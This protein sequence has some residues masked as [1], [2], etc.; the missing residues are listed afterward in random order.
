MEKAWRNN[1]FVMRSHLFHI[2]ILVTLFIIT[3]ASFSLSQTDQYQ[4][5]KGVKFKDGSVIMGTVT[6]L[7]VD[8]VTIRVDNGETIV[9]KFGDVDTFIKQGDVVG[10]TTQERKQYDAA[11]ATQSIHDNRYSSLEFGFM[12]YYYDYSESINSNENG[13]LPGIYL[14]YDYKKPSNIYIKLYGNY[15]DGN[16][17][18]EGE[19]FSGRPLSFDH[20]M[21]FFKFEGD[22]GYT[23]A[24]NEKLL[25]IPYT[26]YGYRYWRRGETETISGAQF[27]KE[28]YTW[29]YIPVGVRV[30]YKMDEKWTIGANAAVHFMFGGIMTAYFSEVNSALPDVD[31]DLGNKPAYYFEMPVSYKYDQNWSFMGTFWYEY[32][33]IGKSDIV[34]GLYEPDSKTNQYG[35]SLGVAYSF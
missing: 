34:Y 29:S 25:L 3:T 10:T 2:L 12:Y 20:S 15:A 28:Q 6:Q 21:S 17:T 13:W 33:E 19:T 32:S 14:S 26:G 11:G 9:R 5:I 24:I 35:F 31:F 23:N 18:Y 22:I 4:S 16:L 30:D 8:T 1:S 27:I 7:N